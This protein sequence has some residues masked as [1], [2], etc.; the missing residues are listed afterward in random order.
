MKWQLKSE[1]ESQ[2]VRLPD[3]IAIGLWH[4]VSL[5]DQRWELCWEPELRTLFLRK[6]ERSPEI[7]LR[8]RSKSLLKFPGEAYTEVKLEFSG[9]G[10]PLCRT[11]AGEWAIFSPGLKHRKSASEA[12]GETVRSPMVG[13]V[14]RLSIEPGQRVERGQ[15]LCVIE[16]MKM[17]NKIFA[18]SSGTI[19]DILV[20]A[21]M[22]VSVN[23]VLAHIQA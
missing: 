4:P 15:E 20:S 5:G 6:D 14:L 13:K 19:K 16:A 18:K 12:G 7:P 10:A 8:Y 2:S 17:E 22:Q 23:Q 3:Q 1:G 9:A 11:L 21:G